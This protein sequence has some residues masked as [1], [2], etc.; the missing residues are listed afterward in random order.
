M[1][2]VVVSP[3]GEHVLSVRGEM[4]RS[5]ADRGHTVL[6]VGPAT[7]L[8]VRTA[9]AEIGVRYMAAPIRRNGLNPFQDAMTLVSLV[10]ILR[11][12]RTD[13]VLVYAAKPV[14]YGSLAA[15]LAG[16]RVRTAMI[17]GA[18]SALGGGEATDRRFISLVVR[19]LYALALRSVHVVFFQNTDDLRLFRSLGLVSSR[20]R[21]V[22]I[23]GSGVDLEKFTP[24]P[25]PAGPPTFLMIARLIRDKGVYEYVEAA[26]RVR[27]VTPEARFQLLGA[28]DTNPTAISPVEL[29]AWRD[30]GIIEYLGATSDVRPVISRCH[31][32]VLPSYGEGM[33]LAILEAMAMARAGARHRC[34]RLSRHGHRRT[35]RAR[36]PGPRRCRAC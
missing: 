3:L 17:T 27:R 18:G 11:R 34:A 31:V 33:P 10:R 2:I 32:V 20:N 1:R 14:I 25:L 8:P 15:R 4:V 28:F 5:I 9:F 23:N 19:R 36:G 35:E 6:V 12:F 13:C 29:Q 30:E 21:V 22:M 24:V 26:R 16:V 7:S